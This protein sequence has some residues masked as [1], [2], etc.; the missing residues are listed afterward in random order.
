MYDEEQMCVPAGQFE[1]FLYQKGREA[2]LRSV[3]QCWASCFSE[4]VM[5][6]RLEVGM[7]LSGLK[8]AVVVQVSLVMWCGG[9]GG[10][11]CVCVWGVGGG[12]GGGGGNVKNPSDSLFSK[13]SGIA[14]SINNCGLCVCVL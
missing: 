13:C 5:S 2:V 12:G 6:H 7:S 10:G 3:R 8:M 1:T 14:W 4:R 11:V 9:G